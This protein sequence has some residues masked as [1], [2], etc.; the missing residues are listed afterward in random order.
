MCM[1]SH[2][3]EEYTGNRSFVWDEK[4]EPEVFHNQRI[5]SLCVLAIC[6]IRTCVHLD[7]SSEYMS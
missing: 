7:M 3:W 4:V 6:N 1:L 2:L 5:H